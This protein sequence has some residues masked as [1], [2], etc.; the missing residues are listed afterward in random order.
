MGPSLNTAAAMNAYLVADRGTWLNFRNR[1]ELA[2]L[3]EGDRK[4]FN[5]YGVMLVNPA[6]HP[7]VKKADGKAFINWLVSAEGQA[8]IAGYRIGGEPL[9]FPSADK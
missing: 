1:G 9:F 8:A 2:V 7:H 4:L 6:R 5:P 3:V